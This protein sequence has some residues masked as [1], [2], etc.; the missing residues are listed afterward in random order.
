MCSKYDSILLSIRKLIGLG[1]DNN[2]FDVDLIIDIN[3]AMMI[4]YQLGVGP[5]RPYSITG[6]SETWNDFF[7]D[8]EQLSLVQT[9]I[10]LKTRLMFD[11]PT[12]GVLH[13]AMERQVQEFE[14][15][16]N[17]QAETPCYIDTETAEE[18]DDGVGL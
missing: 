6:E 16:L 12:T 4:L 17:V 3:A 13:Q 10:Y 8:D 18:E 2:A 7:A 1:I 14:W 11:P 9:Y 15:R 5:S